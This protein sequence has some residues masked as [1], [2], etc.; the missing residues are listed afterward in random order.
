[1]GS[2][3]L[4]LI[5]VGILDDCGQALETLSER[6]AVFESTTNQGGSRD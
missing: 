3:L 6:A 2:A 4:L 5:K 1:M